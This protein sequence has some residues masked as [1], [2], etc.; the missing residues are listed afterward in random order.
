VLGFSHFGDII[1]ADYHTP[2]VVQQTIPSGDMTPLERLLLGHIFEA[3]EHNDGLYFHAETRPNNC[4]TLP[5]TELR[6]AFAASGVSSSATTHMAERLNGVD[7]DEISIQIDLS[8]TFLRSGQ[9]QAQGQIWELVL[10]DIVRR[11]PTLDHVTVVSAFTC[12]RM[13]PDGFGGMATLIT[14][15]TIK[16]KSTDDI[17]EDLLAEAPDAAANS[18]GLREHVLLRLDEASVKAE[19]EVVIESDEALTSL[20]ASMITDADIRAAC[21]AVVH[22]TDLTE[23]Q[24][25]AIFRAALAAIKKAERRRA[26]P[27]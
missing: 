16:G 17:L 23:E 19:I 25:G 12:T 26:F 10:Q 3:E 7:S 27:A 4:L 21:L 6:A 22:H 11:S 8:G 5:L 1:M 20:S 2:T 14:A 9:R 24:G 13:R 18:A 15:D